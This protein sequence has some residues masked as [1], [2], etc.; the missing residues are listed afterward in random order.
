[1]HTDTDIL[2]LLGFS[3]HEQRV[4]DALSREAVSVATLQRNTRIARTNV[5]RALAKLHTRGLARKV[6]MGKTTHWKRAPI[7]SMHKRLRKLAAYVAAEN[8]HHP[9]IAE[10][11]A[12]SNES[13]DVTV[14]HGLT[15]LA[16]VYSYAYAQKSGQRMLLTQF[17]SAL[18]HIAH[19][20]EGMHLLA[21][22]S[23]VANQTKNIT[24]LI[25]S[26]ATKS[27]WHEIS[28]HQ[29]A[30]QEI[31]QR[32]VDAA[33]VPDELAPNDLPAEL[34]VFGDTIMLTDWDAEIGVSITNAHIARMLRIFFRATK[35]YGQQF[36]PGE[37]F[38]EKK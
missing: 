26:E 27:I 10:H 31:S 3:Q 24:E 9:T 20:P 23:A 6:A 11:T 12:W 21:T 28:E 16:D 22:N 17:K 7:T 30:A 33:L 37:I 5:R 32:I 14:I 35:A 25:A 15:K 13:L 4:F 29:V 38:Q 36:G 2:A 18:E 8:E 19:H 34:F 1:M